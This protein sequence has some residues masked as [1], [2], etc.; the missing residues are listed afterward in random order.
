MKPKSILAL[1][2]GVLLA[3]QAFGRSSALLAIDV[4]CDAA[5]APTDC[6]AGLAP[7]QVA[8]FTR[9]FGINPQGD[10]VG[11]YSPDS[12]RV[13]AFL[14]SPGKYASIDHVGATGRVDSVRTNALAINPQGQIGGRYDTPDGVAH[15]YIYTNGSFET[16]DHPLA[17]GFT[18]ITDITPAGDIAGRYQAADKSFHGFTRINGEWTNIDHLDSSDNPDMGALGI[19]GMAL[20]PAGV[21]AGYYQDRNRI[22]HA[23]VLDHGLY[24]T[25]DPPDASSAGGSGGILHI[26]P[27]GDVAGGFTRMGSGMPMTMMGCAFVYR[28]GS[29]TRFSFPGATNPGGTVRDAVSTSLGGINPQGDVVGFYTDHNNLQHG[30]FVAHQQLEQ[31]AMSPL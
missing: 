4:S 29:W 17:A 13:H 26:N 8:A 27:E 3:A 30:F 21:V 20:N 2:F 16:V 10:I 1:I 18:V 25:I 15:G 24:T 11:L 19:Q 6:P 31:I 23:F 14:F 12:I 7:G 28:N 9:A 22:F 5:S